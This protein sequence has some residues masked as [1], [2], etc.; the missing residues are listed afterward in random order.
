MGGF[1][2]NKFGVDS[3]R[4]SSQNYEINIRT[5]ICMK[6]RPMPIARF[7]FGICVYGESIIIIGGID[8]V[9]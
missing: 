6:R 8:Q 7:S 9:V 4:A 5:G 3:V 1:D 2:K